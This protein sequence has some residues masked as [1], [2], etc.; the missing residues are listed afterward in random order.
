MYSHLD[1]SGNCHV[2]VPVN[3]AFDFLIFH[4]CVPLPP[5]QLSTLTHCLLLKHWHK[6]PANKSHSLLPPQPPTFPFSL[7]LFPLFLHISGNDDL[8]LATAMWHQYAL[9]STTSLFL[10]IF[11]TFFHTFS[12]TSDPKILE[13]C[14]LFAQLQNHLICL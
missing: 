2:G 14:H 6:I 5:F 11:L 13:V 4:P 3:H 12:Y 10:C 7:P 1:Q 9:Y 8:H